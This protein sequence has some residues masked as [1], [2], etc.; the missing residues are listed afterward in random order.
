MLPVMYPLVN[1]EN[2]GLIHEEIEVMLDN[3][4]GVLVKQC[5][6][7]GPTLTDPVFLL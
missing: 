1:A 7:F 2:I 5:L 4:D 6:Q 3:V